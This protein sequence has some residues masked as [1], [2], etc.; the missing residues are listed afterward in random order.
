MPIFPKA[1]RCCICSRIA[2]AGIPRPKWFTSEFSLP[3]LPGCCSSRRRHG[4]VSAGVVAVVLYGC[5]PVVGPT[6]TS[7]YNDCALAFF[8]FLTFYGLLIWW[9]H[10]TAQWLA[11]IG[12]LAGFCFA[13]KYTGGL[14]IPVAMVVVAAGAWKQSH[15]LR[16]PLRAALL[17]AGISAVL[18]AAVDTKERLVCGQPGRPTLQPHLPESERH[19]SVGGRVSGMGEA[20]FS[21]A[22]AT[23]RRAGRGAARVDNSRR[24]ARRHARTSLPAGPVRVTGLASARRRSRSWRR[25]LSAPCRGGPNVGTRFLIPSLVFVSLAM[26][27]ALSA[28]PGR[29]RYALGCLVLLGHSLS[30]WPDL[31]LL[32]HSGQLWRLNEYPGPRRCGWNPSTST[33]NGASPTSRP[34]RFWPAKLVPKTA[35]WSLNLSPRPTFRLSFRSLITG[36]QRGLIPGDV[37]GDRAGPLAGR[38]LLVQWNEQALTGFRMVQRRDHAS[39][40]WILSEIQFARNDDSVDIDTRWNIQA[41]PFPW[42]VARLFDNN[43]LTAW[44]S[45]QPLLRGMSV[46]VTFPEALTMNRA[47]LVYRLGAILFG[48]RLFRPDPG[49]ATGCSSKSGLTCKF[50]PSPQRKSRRG[51]ESLCGERA[52]AF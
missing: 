27:M 51:S 39:S 29:W 4:A 14:T 37:G 21:R 12:V 15:N 23:D 31:L 38:E 34:L 46:Q 44:N 1:P 7:S 49:M 24:Q 33:C 5:S 45:G 2:S 48:A 47:D 50:G 3:P 19:R 30:G 25:P 10:R 18:R 32:W 20:L 36:P 22:A 26:G 6:A 41:T 43:P 13:I 11:M 52:S 42:T 16:G 28:L 35:Y 40:H 9:K 8:Q 17:V